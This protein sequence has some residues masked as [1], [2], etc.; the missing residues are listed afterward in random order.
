MIHA[1]DFSL[2]MQRKSPVERPKKAASAL[3][4][5][6]NDT[7]LKQ[8]SWLIK[9]LVK[10]CVFSLQMTKMHDYQMFQ[11]IKNGFQARNSCRS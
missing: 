8:Y 9:Q 11:K 4:W 7:L 5:E 3:F 2:S 6:K 1:M 10:F